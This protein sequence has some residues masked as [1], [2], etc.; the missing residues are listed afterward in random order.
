LAV[1]IRLA[2]DIVGLLLFDALSRDAVPTR[3]LEAADDSL[4]RI[5]MGRLDGGRFSILKAAEFSEF[6]STHK[7][8]K[9]FVNVWLL[10]N[11]SVD[12]ETSIFRCCR[13]DTFDTRIKRLTV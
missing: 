7:S 8:E 9:L 6:S 10:S 13:L 12:I 3:P 11:F 4:T 1:P 2:V 5:D